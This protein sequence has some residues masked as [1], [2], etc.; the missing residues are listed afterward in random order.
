MFKKMIDFFI[1]I[2]LLVVFSLL[3]IIGKKNASNICAILF[4]KM[5]PLTKFENI[6][7]KNILYVWP[8]KSNSYAKKVTHKMWKNIGRNF[9][10]LVHLKSYKPINCSETK[11]I[12]LK[13]IKHIISL[14]KKK[15]KGI[16]FFSAHYGNWELGPII[17]NN[18]NLS[19]LCLYRKSNNKFVEY[20]LQNL[21]AS[22][23]S[24]VPK[25]DI[26]AKKSFL[27]LRKGKS[28]A[29]LMDQKLNEGPLVNFLGKPASTASFIAEIAIRMKLDIIPIKFSRNK[30]NQNIITFYNKTILPKN[31]LSKEKKIEFILKQINDIMSLWIKTKPE[32][33]L[34]IH[35]R[36]PKDL[37]L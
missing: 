25:G 22:N 10:E 5:G 17:I 12:G 26:G 34:W 35:R 1:G 11:I 7:K 37:Y 2:V 33:W 24:Y 8:H 3:K 16:I 30:K 14:N 29:M 32:Y 23:G 21:R 18:L 28:L 36:W 31:N 6:A 4:S 19:P 27:W 13:K 15:K 9:G 20:L